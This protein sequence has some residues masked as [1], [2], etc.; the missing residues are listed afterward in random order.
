MQEGR[1]LRDAPIAFLAVLI[2]A[3]VGAY[4]L[5]G[6]LYEGALNQK[7]ATIESL[8]TQVTGIESQLKELR[9]HSR[10]SSPDT[11]SDPD[12]IYQFERKVGTAQGTKID[13]GQGIVLFG[14]ILES[15]NLNPAKEF[16]YR[17]FILRIDSLAGKNQVNSAGELHQSLVGVTCEIVGRASR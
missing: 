10:A 4:W 14:E 15:Q 6:N 1:A 5:A 11:S 16:R 9:E 3:G 8:K 13:E 7:N 12:G 17:N 2:I